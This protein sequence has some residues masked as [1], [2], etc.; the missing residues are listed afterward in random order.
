MRAS[1]GFSGIAA[2]V[3]SLAA[4]AQP[5]AA[6]T[7]AVPPSMETPADPPGAPS[8]PTLTVATDPVPAGT[9]VVK[10]AGPDRRTVYSVEVEPKGY[11][12][13]GWQSMTVEGIG[14][15]LIG[16]GGLIALAGGDDEGVGATMGWGSLFFGIGGFTIHAARGKWA[17]A[18][19]AAALILGL[20]TTGA[21]VGLAAST[22]RCDDRACRDRYA[23]VGALIGVLSVPVI[24][25]LALGW[26]KRHNS[27]RHAENDSPRR[28]FASIAPVSIPVRGGMGAGVAGTW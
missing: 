23:G 20:P 10:T 4:L 8:A 19:G 1:L 22:G 14:A 6:Q 3:A 5:A 12:F 15:T 28:P 18:G 17:K 25:G 21:L 7:V 9:P 27:Y 13:Y 2:V 16:V 26:D 11:K 24:D